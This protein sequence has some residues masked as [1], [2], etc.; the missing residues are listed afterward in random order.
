MSS[1]QAGAFRWLLSTET[2]RPA[3]VWRTLSQSSPCLWLGGSCCC[4]TCSPLWRTI[5][6]H[7]F[8]STSCP[9]LRA[10]DTSCATSTPRRQTTEYLCC[11][12]LVDCGAVR[13]GKV[14]ECTVEKSGDQ[15]VTDRA[16]IVY[17]CCTNVNSR[18]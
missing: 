9:R 7:A 11:G 17:A 2:I 4:T 5:S 15:F 16:G 3:A 18:R 1:G 13:E 10:E 8:F 12:E 6:D 14:T